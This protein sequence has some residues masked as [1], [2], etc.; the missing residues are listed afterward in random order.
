[1]RVVTREAV[2]ALKYV[3]RGGNMH[4]P[5]GS[6]NM[7]EQG[8]GHVTEAEKKNIWRAQRVGSSCK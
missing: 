2:K 3:G 4:E 7:R 8:G 5:H 1:M 6:Y